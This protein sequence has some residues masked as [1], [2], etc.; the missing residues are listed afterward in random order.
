MNFNVLSVSLFSTGAFI[1]THFG[2][3]LSERQWRDLLE[4]A[5]LEPTRFWHPP[6]DIDGI[7]EAMLK[8]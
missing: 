4:P 6:G 8:D 7:V 3:E 1:S 2:I 5:G